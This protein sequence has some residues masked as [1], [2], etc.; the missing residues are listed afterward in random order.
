[1]AHLPTKSQ[2]LWRVE[3]ALESGGGNLLYLSTRHAHP[4]RYVVTYP[5]EER[6]R[7]LVYI[8][9]LT[10]GGGKKRPADEYRIQ[11]TGTTALRSESGA[12]TVVLGWS[13]SFEAFAGFDHRFHAGALGASPSMQ[14]SEVALNAVQ[15]LGFAPYKKGNG[16]IAMHSDRTSLF[17]TLQ[18][19]K[20]CT[21]PALFR[22]R[23]PLSRG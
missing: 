10:H 12:K 6:Q 13:E 8:W 20:P 5:S 22:R 18:I 3:R 2:L 1:M 19:L 16:E 7:L 14:I 11:I 4:A 15:T 9:N 17:P 23:L 21:R